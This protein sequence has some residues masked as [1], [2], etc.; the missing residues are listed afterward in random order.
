M[1]ILITFMLTALM[2]MTSLAEEMVTKTVLKGKVSILAPKSFSA[3]PKELIE[4]KYPGSRRP[5]EVFSNEDG[6]VSLAFNHT[7]SAMSQDQVVEA[8]KAMSQMFH[9]MHPTAT[10]IRD[11]TFEKDGK[12]FLAMELVTPAIDTDIHN[13]IYGTSVDGTFLLIAFNCTKEE[14]DKWLAIG[15]KMM[16]S[17]KI[18]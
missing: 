6:S 13:I 17:F 8:H 9:R 7:S 10:W 3:M 14:S 12:N 2:G 1:K 4:I 11:E 18:N 16:N 5:T 15:K